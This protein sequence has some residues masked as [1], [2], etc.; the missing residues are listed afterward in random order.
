[1]AARPTINW[2]DPRKGKNVDGSTLPS[3]TSVQLTS[4]H[5]LQPPSQYLV[6]M[7][8][9]KPFCKFW[10]ADKQE[11]TRLDAM[12]RPGRRAIYHSEP[13]WNL[14]VPPKESG[15]ATFRA[16][17]DTDD[18]SS[19]ML[20][21]ARVWLEEI[22]GIKRQEINVGANI[23]GPVFSIG[24]KVSGSKD[25][26]QHWRVRITEDPLV[27]VRLLQGEEVIE[28]LRLLES[29]YNRIIAQSH[30]SMWEL[31]PE[32]MS[33]FVDRP[34]REAS[35]VHRLEP[36]ELLTVSVRI[37]DR[38]DLKAAICL[39]VRDLEDGSLSTTTPVFLT[40]VNDH[41]IATDMTIDMLSS[42]SLELLAQAGEESITER[43]VVEG[44]EFDLGENWSRLEAATEELG[45]STVDDAI[46]FVRAAVARPDEPPSTLRTW[47]SLILSGIPD[48]DEGLAGSAAWPPSWAELGEVD[49]LYRQ[50]TLL[51]RDADVDRVRAIVPS[52]PVEQDNGLR[53]LT[54]LE[55][56]S[57]ESRS[58]E[59]VCAA[60]DRILGGGAATPDH[61]LYLHPATEPEEVPADAPPYPG[62]STE[63]GDG[64][65]VLVM[66]LDGGLLPGADAEH[67]WLVGVHGESENP[68]G[69]YP[70]RILP[71]TGHGTF[72]AGVLRTMAPN[73][74]VW[75]GKTFPRAGAI[76]ESDLVKQ[77]SD[78][79]KGGADVISLSVGTASRK[80][81]PLLG[82]EALEEWL[83]SYPPVAL[84]AAAGNDASRRPFWPAAFP[85]VV[86]VGALS[87][88]RRGRALFS[89]YGPSVDV[90]APGEGLVNAF[91]TGRYLCV[92][93]PNVGQW[94]DFRG[95]ARWSGTCFS[96]PLFAGLVAARMSRT[97]E[98][99][100]TAA[101]SLLQ[102]ART[103]AIASVGPVLSA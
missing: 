62:V 84:V 16:W 65:G 10:G 91:A 86:S 69:G 36:G 47:T 56:T 70:P 1:M 68:I 23:S 15:R 75:V 7:L 19:G 94:R 97:G 103:Q 57:D 45:A 18:A 29:E 48:V 2:L 8:L 3:D 12:R 41:I 13:L 39:R 88:D 55:F 59:E 63:Q 58:V 49:Y 78:A 67:A 44:R 102:A 17:T 61:V 64:D 24:P 66:V 83:R 4:R 76:Y 53:G 81:N 31:S 38:P 73:A 50:R 87:A 34:V 74:S 99:G 60:V 33:Y 90:F 43:T 30:R 72:A 80:D 95:M 51:V 93:P 6:Y 98:N 26:E 46:L 71:Y 32:T 9:P 28:H 27:E 40:H 52:V 82:F 5:H 101:A 79:V 100:R 85:W 89:N 37:A 20:I 25:F 21:S 35:V 54:R 22:S 42:E 14:P 96:A 11:T 77:V 92:E